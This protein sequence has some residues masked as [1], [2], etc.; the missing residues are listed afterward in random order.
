MEQE[1]SSRAGLVVWLYTTKYVNKLKRYGL[2]HYVSK[3]MNY[4]IIY[5]DRKDMDSIAGTIAKQHF[6][7][8]VEESYRCDIPN[9][10]DGILDEVAALSK[11]D[12]KDNMMNS[13][14]K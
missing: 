3:N 6:V 4:A 14:Y 1:K 7:R 12:E 5:V 2:V 13:M 10:F 11:T 9:T 8:K